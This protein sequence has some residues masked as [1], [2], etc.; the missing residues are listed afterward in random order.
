MITI[1]NAGAAI[2]ATNYWDTEHAHGG[3]CYL[4]ANAGVWRLLVPPEAETLLAE[5]RTGKKA[6][7]EP[8]LHLLGHWDVVFEDGTDTPFSVA[9]D[10][11]QIDR[12]MQ[13]GRCRLHVW[14]RRGREIDLVCRVKT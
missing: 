10:P 13:P 14:T 7:I 5:M 9:I 3:L 8:S 2:A 11:K 6:T 1:A 4:S 12:A